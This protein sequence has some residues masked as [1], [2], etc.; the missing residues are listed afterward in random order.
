MGLDHNEYWMTAYAMQVYGGSFVQALGRA[1]HAADPMNQ[2][3]IQWAFPEYMKEYGPGT[4]LYKEAE[5][6]YGLRG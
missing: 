4:E 1:M 5:K 6:T 3:K 2:Q